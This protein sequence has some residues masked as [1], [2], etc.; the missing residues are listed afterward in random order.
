MTEVV[1]EAL[2]ALR[3]HMDEAAT[4]REV[5]SAVDG[6]QRDVKPMNVPVDDKALI[7]KF[8]GIAT[9]VSG[10]IAVKFA[11]EAAQVVGAVAA[12][13]S[14]LDEAI[15]AASV[16]FGS[17]ASDIV[18]WAETTRTALGISESAALEA[19]AGF[20]GMFDQLDV[21]DD[22][23][24]NLS[25]GL[26]QMAGDL[27][28]LR[29]L[30]VDDALGKIRSGLAGEVEP[31]RAYGVN[32]SEVAV[33]AKA[34]ELGLADTGDVLTEQQKVVARAAVIMGDL[35]EAQ[36][37]SENTAEGYANAQ[38]RMQASV[39]DLAATIGGAVTPT[40]AEFATNLA[41]V[42]DKAIDFANAINHIPG[43]GIAKWINDAVNPLFTFNSGLSELRDRYGDASDSAD[44]YADAT[45]AVTDAVKRLNSANLTTVDSLK[46]Q[47]EAG[48]DAVDADLARR[49]A[50]LGVTDAQEKVAES[51]RELAD[52]RAG[53]GKFAEQATKATEKLEAA[54]RDLARAQQKVKELTWDL[55]DAQEAY[56]EAVFHFGPGSKEAR[57]AAHD[58]ESANDDLAN[59]QGDVKKA[60]EDAA[61]AQ[62]EATKA[63]DRSLA[64]KDAAE[65]LTKAQLDLEGAVYRAAKAD[66]DYASK[67]AE[68]KN[69]QLDERDAVVNTRDAL[70]KYADT[71][72]GP[73]KDAVLARIADLDRIIAQM[74]ELDQ[75]AQ[76][77][78]FSA[79]PPQIG[80]GDLAPGAV[81]SGGLAPGA[82][83][84]GSLSGGGAVGVSSLQSGQ[85]VIFNYPVPPD[86][87]DAYLTAAARTPG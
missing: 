43:A 74:K 14:D 61:K 64:Q 86:Q 10:L 55:S 81:G 9:A 65:K 70:A 15:N 23:S 46:K 12:Q 34:V 32:L 83:G 31:L 20:G 3:P 17:S 58:L 68:S 66:E 35:S 36:G 71:L 72:Q 41:F 79:E 62:D 52:A 16:T 27:A 28:S 56:T 85:T 7:G 47:A 44:T 42:A 50:Q 73:V 24:A 11:K 49:Q 33:S 67:S 76:G 54:H 29:N 18:S 37:D 38:R 53:T 69:K 40:L 2:V 26:V 82:A 6:A 75:L 87:V 21:G 78:A 1:A 51:E 5:K 19:A 4:R 57:D 84:A 22:I 45:A 77:P 13:A 8:A 63:A 80:A 60:A 25:K 39:Q 48:I 59:A 30:R